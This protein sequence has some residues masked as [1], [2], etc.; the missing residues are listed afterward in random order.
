MTDS[1]ITFAQLS[2]S[3]ASAV[4]SIAES[5]VR[6]EART[7]QN[8][9]GVV[10][11]DG[12]LIVTA[13][14]V[15][16]RD[17]DI[18]VGLAN[19]DRVAATLVGRDPDHD[20]AV[21]RAQSGSVNPVVK[22]ASLRVG[23]LAIAVARPGGSGVEASLGIISGFGTGRHSRGPNVQSLVRGD[24]TMYP[25]FSGGALLAGSGVA[26]ILSSHLGDGGIAVTTATIDRI[27]QTLAQH[28]HIRKAYL[29]F[30]SQPVALPAPV[31]SRLGREQRSGLIVLGVE[32]GT[33]A[34]KAGMLVGD[35]VVSFSASP[36]ATPDD[37]QA[38]LLA[39][40]IG[41]ETSMVLVR[42][43]ETY[44]ISITPAERAE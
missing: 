4:A 31:Q 1:N 15:V 5:V 37:L 32:A 2:E 11:A 39:G 28:G 6:V 18:N 23:E 34:E 10:W 27:V 17:D 3:A 42:G 22:Y 38:L 41:V 14:H 33:P 9:S 25:G 13:H 21:L 24:L 16:E 30:R 19:G 40:T 8:A 20:I 36:T 35:I 43:G 26:G 12:G 44:T 29:G 7:R